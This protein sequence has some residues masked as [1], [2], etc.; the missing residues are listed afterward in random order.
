M[1][2]SRENTEII[3]VAMTGK[4]VVVN[5]AR[6]LGDSVE[7]CKIEVFVNQKPIHPDFRKALEELNR[8]LANVHYLGGDL[9]NSVQVTSVSISGDA[10][11]LVTLGGKLA[12]DSGNSVPIVSDAI[13]MELELDDCP[14]KFSDLKLNVGVLLNEVFLYTFEGKQAQLK[15]P[16]DQTA[17][18]LATGE[19]IGKKKGKKK[20]EPIGE[21]INQVE[22][23]PVVDEKK[24]NDQV[25]EPVA[26]NPA[27]IEPVVENVSTEKDL[28]D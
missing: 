26:D 23:N 13:D 3:K 11:N 1:E 21:Q 2:I 9:V 8:Y 20:V 7:N 22:I 6:V 15:I 10:A 27:P 5:Y 16:F 12:L 24:D 18:G 14:Y 19:K 28:F 4:K 25:K 17:E